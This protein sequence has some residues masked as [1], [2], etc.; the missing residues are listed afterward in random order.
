MSLTDINKSKRKRNININ[1]NMSRTI[2]I[3]RN[4]EC[5]IRKIKIEY[6]NRVSIAEN[7]LLPNRVQLCLPHL[8]NKVTDNSIFLTDNSIFL[9]DN[10]IFLTDNS[11]F[12]TDNSIFLTDNSIFLTKNKK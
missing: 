11:I 3:L 7:N 4:I 8:L 1:K 6:K 2:K 9:T 10:S 12:L 5:R